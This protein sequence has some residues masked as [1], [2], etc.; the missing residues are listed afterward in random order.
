[1]SHL[2]HGTV[3]A[4]LYAAVGFG[5]LV[6]GTLLVDVLT[7]G[8]LRR[9]I[10]IERNRNAAV[11]L[12]SALLGVAAITVTAILTS[13]S[14]VLSG[15]ASTVIFTALGL[16]LMAGAFLL[17]DLLTP[18]RLRDIVIDPQP[19]PAAWVTATTNVAVAAIICA[20]IS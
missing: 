16:A 20:S 7:A 18:G 13:D 10:W 11:V 3:A 2:L 12:S 19:H 15:L 9:Q 14:D 5:L 4:A 1:M 17:Q 6:L 8:Q